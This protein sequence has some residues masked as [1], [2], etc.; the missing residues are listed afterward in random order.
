MK[1]LNKLDKNTLL[2][3]ENFINFPYFNKYKTVIN[4]FSYLKLHYP[5]ISDEHLT[6]KKISWH[7]YKQKRVNAEKVRK[8]ISQFNLLFEKFLVIEKIEKDSLLNQNILLGELKSMGDTKRFNHHYNILKRYEKNCSYRDSAFY[9]N[10]FEAE[11]KNLEML[12]AKKDKNFVASLKK[13]TDYLDLYL[14]SLK[15][16][17]LSLKQAFKITIPPDIIIPENFTNEIYPLIEASPDTFRKYHPYI[18]ILYIKNQYLIT[19]DYKY[20]YDLEEFQ[21]QRRKKL[22]GLLKFEFNDTFYSICANMEVDEGVPEKVYKKYKR[23]LL[24][25][26]DDIFMKNKPDEYAL[27]NGYI[28]YNVY[29]SAVE[30]G[31]IFKKYNWIDS[32][33]EKNKTLLSPD[34]QDDTYYLAK[35]MLSYALKDYGMAMNY[36][37]KISYSI[38]TYSEIVRV[39]IIKV[40]Y[41]LGDYNAVKSSLNNMR[42]IIRSKK[43]SDVYKSI[44]RS[45]YYYARKLASIKFETKYHKDREFKIDELLNELSKDNTDE[46]DRSWFVSKLKQL[47]KAVTVV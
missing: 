47:R 4:L 44:P 11:K 45:F 28:H 21:K 41:D 9:F 42:D 5:E 3:F 33:I 26:Y 15:L 37:S 17:S 23:K 35:V 8:L 25:F 22:T 39:N 32:F 18:Y 19:R 20:I 7:V 36:L 27:E 34:I 24:E 31:F 38:S 40:Q 43:Y 10:L 30:T 6:K 14:I 12:I 2:R 46:T 1:R 16:K 29:I 13:Y